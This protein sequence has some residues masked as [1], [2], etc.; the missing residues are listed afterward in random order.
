M[1]SPSPFSIVNIDWR[2]QVWKAGVTI[3][4]N[5]SSIKV[6]TEKEGCG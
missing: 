5:V 3:T 2:Y 1:N 6:G 4:D